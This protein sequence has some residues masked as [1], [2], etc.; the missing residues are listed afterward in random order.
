MFY[1]DVGRQ[2]SVVSERK[3]FD[4]VIARF[5]FR[6]TFSKRSR[7][8]S[9]RTLLPYAQAEP[10]YRRSFNIKVTSSTVPE[11]VTCENLQY[12]SLAEAVAPVIVFETSVFAVKQYYIAT[13]TTH[14]YLLTL[15]CRS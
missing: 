4:H 15:N 5:C 2:Y 8:T 1:S 10:S 3:L 14:G 7:A 9:H 11:F 6:Y 13:V 12:L